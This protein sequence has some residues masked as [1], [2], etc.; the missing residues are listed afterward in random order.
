VP[1]AWSAWALTVRTFLTATL[2]PACSAW[3]APLRMRTLSL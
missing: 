3:T 2:L 1:G